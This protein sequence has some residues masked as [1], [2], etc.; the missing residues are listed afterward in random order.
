MDGQ[1]QRYREIKQLKTQILMVLV[2]Y[3]WRCLRICGHNG[4]LVC[5]VSEESVVCFEGDS[6]SDQRTWWSLRVSAR[7][8]VSPMGGLAGR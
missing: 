1:F 5:N 6:K 7:K 3:E 4:E 2:S 8:V